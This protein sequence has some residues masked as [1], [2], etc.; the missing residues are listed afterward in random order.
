M[1]VVCPYSLLRC[2]T[3]AKAREKH[4]SSAKEDKSHVSRPECVRKKAVRL[5]KHVLTFH[6]CSAGESAETHPPAGGAASRW[7]AAEGWAGAEVQVWSEWSIS[8]FSWISISVSI[9]LND[10]VNSFPF[11]S[12]HPTQGLKKSWRN[13]MRRWMLLLLFCYRNESTSWL[14]LLDLICRCKVIQMIFCLWPLAKRW[15]FSASQL[16]CSALLCHRRTWG[17]PWKQACLCL[18]RTRWCCSTDSQSTKERP[19]RR[20][21]RGATWRTKVKGGVMSGFKCSRCCIYAFL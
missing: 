8:T 7:N 3:S 5:V 10:T 15:I 14:F 18:R 6:V 19:T 17:R 9:Y 21:R 16:L 12:G 20:R 4:S 11:S 1:S 2:S 13:W